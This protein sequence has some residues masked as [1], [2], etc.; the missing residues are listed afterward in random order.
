[1]KRWIWI[2]AALVAGGGPLM[3]AVTS[4]ENDLLKVE[5]DDATSSFTLQSL[6]NGQMFVKDAGFSSKGGK[7]SKEA[8]KSP[9]FG[10]GEALVIERASGAV[11][12]IAL[13]PGEAFAFIQS[14]YRNDSKAEQIIDR[15]ETLSWGVDVQDS[16]AEEL[17]IRSSGAL[18]DLGEEEIGSHAFLC[19]ANKATRNG[20]VAGWLTH[21][22]G[23]GVLFVKKAEQD[24]VMRAQL[25][26][27][28]LKVP[29]N[30]TEELETLVIG[31]FADARLG[32][33]GYADLVAKRYEVKLKQKPVVYCTW[34]NTFRDTSETNLAKTVDI[35]NDTVADYGLN[36]VQIDDGWQAGES[37]KG[38]ARDFFHVNESYASGMRATTDYIN[39]AGL[40]SGIWF[41][42]FSGTVQ[43]P[44]FADKL[45]LFA[46]KDGKAY[47]AKWGGDCLDMTHPESQKYLADLTRLIV[48]DWGYKYLKLDGLWTGSATRQMYINTFYKDDAIGES[49]LHDPSMTH[50]E[51]YR[52]GLGI[53]RKE[54]GDDTYILGCNVSQ[55]GRVLGASYGLVDAMRVGPDN[56]AAYPATLKGPLF[57]G[58][59]YF[60]NDRVWHNDPDPA[61]VRKK[62]G[63]NDARMLCSW[64]SLTGTLTANSV[65]YTTLP[66]ERMDL[67]RRTMPTH[68]W[69][70]RPADF[71]DNDC[72]SVW[73]A[74]DES[75]PRKLL[76]L[77][78]WG[79]K[80]SDKLNKIKRAKDDDIDIAGG[81]KKKLKDELIP[82]KPM[83][84][85]FSYDLDWIGLDGSKQYVGY[86]YWSGEFVEPFG[87]KIERTVEPRT[88]QIFALAEVA[89][90]PQV[91][92][93]SRSISQGAVDLLETKWK[94]KKLIG[95]SLVTKNDPYEIRI[96]AM[97]GK[98]ARTCKSV[99][100]SEADEKAGVKIKI[101]EQ[102]GWKLRVQ[103]D[104]PEN[105]E[106]QWT[107]S[108]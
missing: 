42:P 72:P 6:K 79:K 22:R 32:L 93:T 91:L 76:G 37:P 55:N 33:E 15:L 46:T 87:G 100:V 41:M 63:L 104:A 28:A 88:C 82:T 68:Y 96:A 86:E 31:G 11:D 24:A 26:F 9:W 77:F 74:E 34:Y 106:V 62:L 83:D 64:I 51:A 48:H 47:N 66:V 16:K 61:Y 78:N 38:P 94:R 21:H 52:T 27:G 19:A 35:I 54:S 40:V 43:D 84:P 80:A 75:S 13:Y 107:A 69:K 67:L 97:K 53:V 102:D 89:K 20:V 105:R 56:R 85:A 12:R 103:I 92:G 4:L 2:C 17:T 60:Y 95:R 73:L 101:V 7:V 36:V 98:G 23:S 45:H 39:K 59:T 90:V 25:D 1:M 18:K 65:D 50:I 30:A 44:W 14:T 57:G 10:E 49:K 71:F 3:A 29:A 81:K 99:S 58:R 5:Y 108:F 8:V 70:A